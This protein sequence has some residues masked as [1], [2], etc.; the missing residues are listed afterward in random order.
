MKWEIREIPDGKYTD[1]GCRGSR[2]QAFFYHKTPP[3][4]GVIS[5][6]GG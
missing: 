2:F 5:L 6:E 1:V 3:V 4:V